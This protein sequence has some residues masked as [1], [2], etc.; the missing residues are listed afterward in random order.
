MGQWESRGGREEIGDETLT[1]PAK[2]TEPTGLQA[3]AREAAVTLDSVKA[4]KGWNWKCHFLVCR[5][6]MRWL[7]G[8]TDL[9]DVSLSELQE[10]VAEPRPRGC[11]GLGEPRQALPSF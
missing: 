10:L 3:D 11:S 5:Q 6:R 9:M 2:G 7:G 1:L 4:F 8:I